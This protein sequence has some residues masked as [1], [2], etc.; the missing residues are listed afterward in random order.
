MSTGRKQ[1]PRRAT[2]SAHVAM[3]GAAVAP[4][5]DAFQRIAKLLKREI[6]DDERT[7]LVEAV[8]RYREEEAL[9]VRGADWAALVRAGNPDSAIIRL[10]RALKEL[11]AALVAVQR[12]DASFALF[13]DLDV[14]AA[15]DRMLGG[16]RLKS[17]E[18]VHRIAPWFSLHVHKGSIEVPGM[19]RDVVDVRGKPDE[20]NA[21]TLVDPIKNLASDVAAALSLSVTSKA[22][23][24][25]LRALGVQAASSEA[26]NK[27]I[28]ATGK[29]SLKK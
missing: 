20:T 18:I 6:S 1:R 4:A 17:A 10:E 26:M 29:S 23:A 9:Q 7:K 13:N 8:G 22:T 15:H 14:A 11:S 2:I 3:S 25:V 24:D 27:R 21:R 28:R 19:E 5:A 12:D 16:L